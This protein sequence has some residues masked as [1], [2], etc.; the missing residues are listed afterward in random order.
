MQHECPNVLMIFEL[1]MVVPFTN[2][3]VERMFSRMARVKTDWRNRLGRD[4]L[5]A[6]LRIGEDGPEMTNFDPSN[7]MTLWY[8]DKVRRLTAGP[9]NY[10]KSRKI[11]AKEK[12]VDISTMTL[13]DL[14]GDSDTDVTDFFA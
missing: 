4:R 13:S 3:K 14:E 2:A 6:L 7:A 1:L 12:Q 11:N 9:H 10:P 5:D 8:N